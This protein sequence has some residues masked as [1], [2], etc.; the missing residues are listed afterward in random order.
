MFNEYSD[1]IELSDISNLNTNRITDMSF[2]FDQC[3]SLSDISKLNTNNV[4]KM[5]SMFQACSSLTELP[6]IG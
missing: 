4:N 1:L 5:N 6:D 3:S 2:M